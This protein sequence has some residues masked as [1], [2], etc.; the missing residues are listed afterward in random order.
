MPEPISSLLLPFAANNRHGLVFN[1]QTAQLSKSDV[2]DIFHIGVPYS[3]TNAWKSASG[4]VASNKIDATLAAL[5]EGVERYSAAIV[6]V[7]LRS[8]E[9]IAKSERMD[10]ADWTLFS[11]AQRHQ[12]SFPFSNL[13]SNKCLYTDVFRLGTNE[14]VW[15]PHP[16]VVLRDDFET[17]IPTSSGL[18][19]APTATLATLRAV[20][21]LI[22]RDALM[23]TWLHS[24]PAR[25]IKTLK[26]YLNSVRKL[27]GVINVLDLTP[28]YSPF[29]V[30]AVAGGIPLRGKWRYSLGVAC[31]ETLLQ[32]TDKAFLEWCQGVYFAGVYPKY[33]DTKAMSNSD[34]V[35]SFDD[36]AIYYTQNPTEWFKIPLLEQRDKLFEPST[37]GTTQSPP[38]ALQKAV[39]S[40]KKGGVRL[41][42]RD[43]TTIDA[44]QSG[45][46]VVR[47]LS[48]DLIPINAHH[49]WPF[50]GGNAANITLRYNWATSPTQFPNPFPHP[51]G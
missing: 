21:E 37:K 22:E 24:L 33:V 48:P 12:D 36:H 8:R 7:P 10:P 27:G 39:S 34:D 5:G 4:G 14:K 11:E 47:V 13:Y 30:I 32:A 3:M 49:D 16:L 46:R 43:L 41:Y 29:P 40:L 44:L 2:P 17:G 1:P 18:A 26:K 6:T 23:A 45:V 35:T 31:R 28:S 42:Y 9:T 38:A 25:R 19:T 50:L 51:L 20:Q 15:V